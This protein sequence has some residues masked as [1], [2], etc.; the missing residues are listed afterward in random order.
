MCDSKS[1]ALPCREVCHFF[2]NGQCTRGQHCHYL[3]L[4]ETG[5]EDLLNQNVSGSDG[6]F[7]TDSRMTSDLSGSYFPADQKSNFNQPIC[8]H[9]LRR[10]WCRFGRACK[11]SHAVGQSKQ[12]APNGES[13][14]YDIS[15][16]E[17]NM[18]AN[19]KIM[20]E[21]LSQEEGKFVSSSNKKQTTAFL[22]SR[23]LCRF[24]KAGFCSFGQRCRFKHS[25][26][27]LHRNPFTGM[28]LHSNESRACALSVGFRDIKSLNS[29]TLSDS[30]LVE[31]FL[32]RHKR[33]DLPIDAISEEQITF[34]AV[35][36]NYPLQCSSTKLTDEELPKNLRSIEIEQLKKRYPHAKDISSD[37]QSVLQFVFQCT[38]PDWPYD[39]KEINL[40]VVFPAHYPSDMMTIILL[41]DRQLPETVRRL[42]TAAS[43]EW[44]TN[45]FEKMK[46]LGKSDLAFR[47]FLRWLDKNAEDLFTEA[48]K[49]LRREKLA[50]ISGVQFIS[51]K[52]LRSKYNSEDVE[53][54]GKEKRCDANCDTIVATVSDVD[55]LT[56][57]HAQD[58]DSTYKEV[59]VVEER[60]FSEQGASLEVGQSDPS[61]VS[62]LRRG[63]EVLLQ[64]LQLLNCAATIVATNVA[65]IISCIRCSN[66]SEVKAKVGHLGKIEC[67]YCH[68]EHLILF[69]QNMA[70]QF[71]S[72]IGYLDL[73]GCEAFDMILSDCEFVIS[74]LDCS[75]DNKLQALSPGQPNMTWCF[76]CHQKL[77]V[78]ADNG[79]FVK[80]STTTQIDAKNACTVEVQGRVKTVKDPAIV[81]GKPLPGNG[82]CTH[83]KKS[84]RWFRFPCCGKAYPCDHC[85]DEQERGHEMKRAN[86]MICGFC[87]KEQAYTNEH[88]CV[89]CLANMTYKST[90]H[91]EGGTG[92]RDKLKMSRGD[93]K[94]YT[95]SLKIA[96]R[97]SQ[98]KKESGK[99]VTKLR[100]V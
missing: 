38:D 15:A 87:A 11:Y 65:L 39:V 9:F 89:N 55:S 94:K 36:S 69:R 32:P 24:Y 60:N 8:N 74:C 2:A 46:A 21:S 6:N 61:S 73:E 45:R 18:I 4:R 50:E 34:A 42:V 29:E 68:L 91:W 44:V 5:Q 51:A 20:T 70:H 33:E 80:L 58:E 77:A 52:Q 56:S 79:R 30:V 57:S 49:E 19:G 47:P 76:Y 23:K 40:Q 75:K 99:K 97:S 28:K 26:P 16:A 67:P 92:C 88:P 14:K 43:Q 84:F 93:N 31:S 7:N 22:S 81:E 96:S 25:E 100:H 64:N 48:L 54:E 66:K 63:T 27:A 86:R 37:G 1:N 10:G 98:N 35:E 13:Q 90:A 72:V 17:C 83:F 85:H 95:D 41:E 3:H 62:P 82:T 59:S 71:C 12:F 78:S 53:Q